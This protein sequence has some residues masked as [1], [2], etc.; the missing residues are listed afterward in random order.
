MNPSLASV[1]TK[2]ASKQS[3]FTIKLLADRSRKEDA[4]RAYAY[5]RWVDDVL[6][7]NSDSGP[8]PNENET[9][10]RITFLER[11]K[12]LLEKCI[13][14]E[15]P[16]E[17]IPQEEMLVELIQS[18]GNPNCGLRDYLRNMMLVMDF[19]VRR[20][21]RLITQYELNMYT[22]RLAIAVTEN[23]HYFIGNGDFAPH[24]DTRYLAV[25]AA[26]IAHM[27][28][29]TYIDSKLGYYNIPR[30]V[31]KVHQ[32]TLED[33][34][35]AAYRYWVQERVALARR[36]FKAGRSYFRRVENLRLRLAGLAY[37][38][39]FEWVLDTIEKDDFVLRKDYHERK[40]KK[41]AL[42]MGWST[43]LSMINFREEEVA[44]ASVITQNNG[45]I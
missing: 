2:A 29:D 41:T 42:E 19:D 35:S 31:L 7:A 8:V 30:E 40:N 28:R 15:T 13:R 16:K 1:I 33:K 22:H 27:L 24:D 34:D 36:Y 10:E 32:L 9:R 44:S 14:H 12:S 23:L 21:G 37:M 43:I 20:R 26:H 25:C 5:F 38:A 6:D 18:D 39:R 3:Y 45:K 17:V 4:F 11:Q